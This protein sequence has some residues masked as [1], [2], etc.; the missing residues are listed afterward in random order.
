MAVFAPGRVAAERTFGLI[1]KHATPDI[2]V[3]EAKLRDN[4][5]GLL[6]DH[7]V[8]LDSGLNVDVQHNPS[9]W[10]SAKAQV[11]LG[12]YKTPKACAS[13]PMCDRW[14]DENTKPSFV[15]RKVALYD[16]LAHE[17]RH[18]LPCATRVA[19][20]SVDVG[21][22][23]S[24]R[25]ELNCPWVEP[26][27]YTDI[28]QGALDLGDAPNDQPADAVAL[29]M[30]GDRV[31]PPRALE[32]E[33]DATGVAAIVKKLCDTLDKVEPRIAKTNGVGSY[34][35]AMRSLIDDTPTRAQRQ[36]LE[37]GIGIFV[38]NP[39]AFH[40]ARKRAMHTAMACH[41]RGR[42]DLG[43]QLE[44]LGALIVGLHEHTRGE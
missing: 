16:V 22:S 44:R 5:R 1:T 21:P 31:W 12:S 29:M 13:L 20:K 36:M 32:N 14:G 38:R 11:R 6:A 41:V 8:I 30:D 10:Q 23:C 35:K 39:M 42:S 33:N 24:M 40:S 2:P 28:C 19:A 25:E 3:N 37:L 7:R 43:E 15:S 27:T 4:L 34:I 18:S 26:L 17:S 9:N